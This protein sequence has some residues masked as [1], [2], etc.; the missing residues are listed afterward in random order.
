MNES[1]PLYLL[2]CESADSPY[3]GTWRFV[4]ECVGQSER[5]VASGEETW[6]DRDRLA[7]LSVVRGL[8]ALPEPSRVTLLT[9]SRYVSRGFRYGLS[10]WRES[11]FRWERFGRLAPVR[12]ADLWQRIAQAMQFHRVDC[13]PWRFE[14]IDAEEHDDDQLPVERTHFGQRRNRRTIRIEDQELTAAAG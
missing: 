10:V 11:G 7:L 3:G 6:R 8:E 12:D 1:T 4:L 9:P 14:A 5:L 2:F 13:R